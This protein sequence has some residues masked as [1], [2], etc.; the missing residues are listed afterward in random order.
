MR[1]AALAEKVMKKCFWKEARV[2]IGVKVKT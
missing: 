2:K 1:F